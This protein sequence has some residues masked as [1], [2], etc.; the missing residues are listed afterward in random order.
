L[1]ASRGIRGASVFIEFD[2][3]PRGFC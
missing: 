1:L 3:S 2:K